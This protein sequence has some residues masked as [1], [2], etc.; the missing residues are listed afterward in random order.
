MGVLIKQEDSW[1]CLFLQRVVEEEFYG[2]RR[3]VL[4]MGWR[5]FVGELCLM[6]PS[7]VVKNG[8]AETESLPLLRKQTKQSVWVDASQGLFLQ[9]S[10]NRSLASSWR[11]GLRFV[12]TFTKC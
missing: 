3:A 8:S 5:R 7:L 9:S 2:F 6:L 11:G 12:W 4:G 1:R 10:Y